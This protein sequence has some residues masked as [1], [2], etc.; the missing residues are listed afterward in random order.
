MAKEKM[1]LTFD[2]E[3]KAMLRKQAEKEHM[4][5]SQYITRMVLIKEKV[6]RK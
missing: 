4:S 6:V 3:V 1:T 2:S 5:V